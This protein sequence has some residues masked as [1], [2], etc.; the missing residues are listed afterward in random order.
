M[1]NAFTHRRRGSMRARGVIAA[2]TL[3]GF[4]GVTALAATPAVAAPGDTSA[5]AGAA[6]GNVHIGSV[7]NADFAQVIGVQ[8]PFGDAQ[9]TSGLTGTVLD[10]DWATISVDEYGAASESTPAASQSAAT[11]VSASVSFL[12]V[13]VATFT[14]L[15]AAIT[16][17][18][19]QPGATAVSLGSAT[20]VGN[21]VVGTSAIGTAA[22]GAAVPVGGGATADLTGLTLTVLF[23]QQDAPTATGGQATAAALQLMLG[24]TYEGAPFPN[25]VVAQLAFA[26]VSCDSLVSP[27]TVT[28]ITPAAGSVTGGQTVTITGTGFAPVST[29]RFGDVAAT[30]VVVDP[31][32]TSLTAVVPAAAATG[33]AVV[34]VTGPDGTSA[35]ATYTY[36]AA[37]PAPTPT[38][39]PVAVLAE[40]GGSDAGAL[41]VLAVSVLAAGALLAFAAARRRRRA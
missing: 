27:V 31:S 14:D 37:P 21:P 22:L 9:A 17:V 6:Q 7:L 26:A 34:T 29:V 28:G 40:S 15:A 24:G 35:T 41:P 2:A 12:G 39:T 23:T 5:A 13:D 11:A 8:V 36:I 32:G 10:E 33:D 3:V 4:V 18:P 16:C 38:P 20:I 30:G 1:T 25:T 19:G